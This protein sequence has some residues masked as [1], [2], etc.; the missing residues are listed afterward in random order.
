MSRPE[1]AIQ[2]SLL[3]QE[4]TDLAHIIDGFFERAMLATSNNDAYEARMAISQEEQLNHR[5]EAIEERGM[6]ILALQQPVLA[7]DLRTVVGG[8]VVTQRLHRAGHGALGIAR[9]AIDI[10]GLSGQEAPPEDLLKLSKAARAMLQDAVASFTQP[11]G[12][13]AE[14][15]IQRDG[16]ID[17]GYRQLREALLTALGGSGYHEQPDENYHR[18]LTYWLWIA[19]KIERIADHSVV[20]ARRAIQVL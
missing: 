17:G 14:S 16:D 11:N 2:M 1:F 19:H 10:S 7:S 20:I 4:V 5:A 9:L 8:L 18:R 15:V 3:R 13:L 12:L 6:E